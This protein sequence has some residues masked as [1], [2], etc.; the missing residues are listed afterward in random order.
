MKNLLFVSIAFPP[1]NDPE[2]L[3]TA[4]YF[5]YLLKSEK[6]NVQ[7]LTSKSPTLYM[8]VD[9]NLDKY[10]ECFDNILEIP[11]YENK[12]ISYLT[13]RLGV[14]LMDKP[15]SKFTFYWQW[16]KALKL[17]ARPPDVIYSRSF[18][19][20]SALMALKLKKEWNKPW[21]MHLSDP[22]VDSPLHQ[23]STKLYKWHD[24][25]ERVCMENATVISLTSEKAVAFY[26]NKYPALQNKIKLFPNVYDE[27]DAVNKSWKFGEK[28]TFVY[29]GGLV[30]DR[31]PDSLFN[32]F[33]FLLEMNPS[34]FDEV[35]FIFAGQMDR[36]NQKK[37]ENRKYSFFK[38]LGLVSYQ[39]AL[40]LQQKACILLVIDNP[41]D[42]PD[43]AM[44]FPS[45]LL[46]YM[47]AKKRVLAIT[48]PESAS[49]ILLNNILSD[50]IGHD[51]L[52][53]LSNIILSAISAFRAR[54]YS[55][56]LAKDLDKRYSASYNS[57]RLVKTIISL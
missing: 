23:Y 29:T 21:I 14:N 2:C 49:N 38:H 37:I 44:F 26:G 11:I 5:K 46:D 35:E 45:K 19:L 31:G 57:Q 50:C 53:E 51:K 55:Y 4:K 33:D 24:K 18:P 42:N 27:E 28:L 25:M 8:P 16:K 17:I 12:Y 20:S 40:A 34:C 56:F 3:Q 32:A 1:K 22:W 13:R 52:T 9:H 41:I 7:V 30:N 39:E 48:T 6:L 47:L 54:D 10:T 36:K 15:D 43:Q